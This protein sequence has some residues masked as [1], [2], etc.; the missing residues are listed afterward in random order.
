[1]TP[2][3]IEAAKTEYESHLAKWKAEN[4]EQRVAAENKRASWAKI[5][6]QEQEGKGHRAGIIVSGIA[7][8]GASTSS[9]DWERLLAQTRKELPSPADARDLT[10]GEKDGKKTEEELAVSI[11]PLI[12]SRIVH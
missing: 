11:H 2:E 5:R 3:A 9:E 4:A 12:C 7:G 10:S 1:M 6:E 8:P